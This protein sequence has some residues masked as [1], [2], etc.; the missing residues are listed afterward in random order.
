MFMRLGTPILLLG[1][2][3]V[4][5]ASNNVAANDVFDAS[6]ARTSQR[7]TGYFSPRPMMNQGIQAS[8]EN[9][10]RCAATGVCVC[11][12]ACQCTASSCN[13]GRMPLDGTWGSGY[14][15]P[16]NGNWG[17]S[18]GS[19][20]SLPDCCVSGTCDGSGRFLAPHGFQTVLRM[21]SNWPSAAPVQQVPTFPASR[22]WGNSPYFQ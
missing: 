4:G 14:R 6:L 10:D 2:A 18:I 19:G 1:L 21:P 3:L 12:S 20:R 16:R 13:R 15:N 8:C 9:C 22:S 5:A 7:P 17:T 11:S